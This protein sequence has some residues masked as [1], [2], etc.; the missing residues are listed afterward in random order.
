MHKKL[1]PPTARVTGNIFDPFPFQPLAGEGV[2][3]LGELQNGS[4]SPGA[5]RAEHL[6][7]LPKTSFL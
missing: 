3:G 5:V 2:G 1:S 7:R 6:G 4:S